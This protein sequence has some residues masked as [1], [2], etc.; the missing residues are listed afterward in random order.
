MNPRLDHDGAAHSRPA[1]A[2]PIIEFHGDVPE[3]PVPKVTVAGPWSVPIT[4]GGV[5][6]LAAVISFAVLANKNASDAAAGVEQHA[7]KITRLETKME[8]VER[9]VGEM[10]GDVKEILRRLPAPPR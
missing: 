10:K 8:G 5:L 3:P 1:G 6:A 9:D 7:P 4:V 2:P